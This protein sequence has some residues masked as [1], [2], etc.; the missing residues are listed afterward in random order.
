MQ[1]QETW[2]LLI[3][4]K[5]WLMMKVLTL[6]PHYFH[7]IEYFTNKRQGLYYGDAIF[8]AALWRNFYMGKQD[9]SAVDLKAALEY[10]RRNL[11][12]LESLDDETILLGNF[13][14]ITSEQ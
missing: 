13:E 7:F 5:S 12:Y 3:K 8:A 6:F 1:L 2:S 14:F 10:V 9:I 11:Q 4:D